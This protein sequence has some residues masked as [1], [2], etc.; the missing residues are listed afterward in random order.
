MAWMTEPTG[1]EPPQVPLGDILGEIPLFREI[2]RVLMASIGPVNWELARQVG[3]AAASWGTDDPAP[4]EED[5]AG[6]E[7]T[8]RAAEL[9]VVDLTALPMPL[10]VARVEAVRR[11]QW[12]EA[13]IPSLREVIEP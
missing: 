1:S 11:A 10:D 5:R 7:Q 4:S 13:S 12:V 9:A 2:Q 8:V 3:I 6:L